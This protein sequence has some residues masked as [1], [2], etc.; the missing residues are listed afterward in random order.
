VS[1]QLVIVLAA[2]VA[3]VILAL[4]RLDRV[5][6]HRETFTGSQQAVFL[7]AFLLAPP[8]VLQTILGPKGIDAVS[9]TILY[10]AVVVVIWALAWVAALLV[11]RFAPENRRQTLLMALIGRDTS[12][13]IPFDPPLTEELAADVSAVEQANAAFSRGTGFL[14][15]S[16]RAGFAADW[17][18]LDEATRTL[19]AG[20]AEQ[21]RLR[22]GVSEQA[23][24]VAADARG[25]LDT[26]RREAPTTVGLGAGTVAGAG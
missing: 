24:D 9:A 2:I 6:S 19:E 7:A 18:A 13:F 22:L 1:F 15:E 12:G 17:Q 21:R 11:A 8:I 4:I 25:R 20:I 5:R 26:L 23:V 16:H 14:A 10:I 3:F